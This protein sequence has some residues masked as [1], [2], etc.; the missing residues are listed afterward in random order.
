MKDVSA[1]DLR[2]ITEG[3]A[4]LVVKVQ[5]A[6]N[7]GASVAVLTFIGTGVA[8]E[9]LP[10]AV[11]ALFFFA[12]GVFLAARI[13]ALSFFASRHFYEAK[14]HANDPARKEAEQGCAVR[15]Y[16]TSCHCVRLSLAAFAV[17]VFVLCCSM[18]AAS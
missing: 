7:G 11:I 8:D 1:K 9:Y 4:Q 18:L 15:T 3:F 12:V 2:Y 10:F 14:Q 6:M 17:G 5:F 13:S 16:R